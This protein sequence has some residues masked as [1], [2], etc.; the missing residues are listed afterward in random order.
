MPRHKSRRKSKQSA[1]EQIGPAL[2]PVAALTAVPAFGAIPYAPTGRALTLALNV[3]S[4]VTP[5]PSTN[6]AL[7]GPSGEHGDGF[8]DHQDDSFN[9]DEDIEEAGY[10]TVVQLQ[11][12]RTSENR[13]SY[14]DRERVP[15]PPTLRNVATVEHVTPAGDVYH[16]LEPYEADPVEPDLY[17]VPA[18]GKGPGKKTV[19]TQE[20]DAS[21]DRTQQDL[22]RAMQAVHDMPVEDSMKNLSENRQ[23]LGSNLGSSSGRGTM[24]Q[25]DDEEDSETEEPPPL[26]PP[27][28]DFEPASE[29][30]RP[31]HASKAEAS[32]VQVST[33]SPEQVSEASPD[34]VSAVSPDQVSAALSGRVS[35]AKASVK[36][37]RRV[38][39]A[40]KHE[41]EVIE[42][43]SM[44]VKQVAASPHSAGWD[45]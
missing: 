37:V 35:E 43:V 44:P 34:R 6:E 24:W 22:R 45:V 29:A 25:D 21:L 20:E 36:D 40:P 9:E 27:P 8:A 31:Q 12:S 30:A 2:L 13:K 5:S 19:Q 15:T 39:A 16:I 7:A 26:P 11:A 28:V 42:V 4:T 32:P 1:L 41:T 23:V 14:S 33:S 10:S 17:A 3:F 18:K 38:E